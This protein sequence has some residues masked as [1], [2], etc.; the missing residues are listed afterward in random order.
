V[1]LKERFLRISQRIIRIEPTLSGQLIQLGLD[2]RAVFRRQLGQF[3]ENLR[4]AHGRKL[5]VGECFGRHLGKRR[6]LQL[7]HPLQCDDGFFVKYFTSCSTWRQRLAKR[8]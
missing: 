5:G 3:R 8:S 4:F 7:P 6:R 1:V 2:F